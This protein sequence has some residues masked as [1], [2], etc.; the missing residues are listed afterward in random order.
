VCSIP[1]DRTSS[2]IPM[3]T[4]SFSPVALLATVPDGSIPR[5]AS[6]SR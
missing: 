2:T 6:S 1:G 5:H 4:T 3:S